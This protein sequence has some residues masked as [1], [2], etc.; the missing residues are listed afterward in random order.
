MPAISIAIDDTVH[1][2]QHRSTS[3][4][5]GP[6][7][8]QRQQEEE[9]LMPRDD[10]TIVQLSHKWTYNL[11]M[12]QFLR[13][14][15]KVEL[16]VHL[17]GSF[18]PSILLSHLKQTGQY[19]CLP[20]EAYCP[21]DQSTLA[22]RSSVLACK[23]EHEFRSL[24]TCRGKRSLGSMLQ[25]FTIFIPIVRGNL[26]LM[27]RLAYDFVKRQAKQNIIYTEVRYS[28]HLLAKGG[29]IGGGTDTI[30]D[31]IPVVDA[32][33]KGL[34]RGEKDFGIIVNQILC[35]IAWRPDW[36]DDVVQLAHDRRNDSPCAIV[37]VD[38]AAGE[39][40]FDK[41]GFPHLHE[42][43]FEAFQRAK[44]LGLNITIHAGEVGGSDFVCRAVNEYGATRIG[45]GYQIAQDPDVMEE[46]RR[47]NIHFEVCPTSSDETGGWMYDE[48]DGRDWKKHPAIQMMRYGLN[49]GLNSDDPAVFDTSLT[50]QYRIA[51]GKMGLTKKC[52]LRSLEYS[53]HS[54]FLDQEGKAMLRTRI[55]D[56]LEAE[57]G[58]TNQP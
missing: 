30:V 45:H 46:M 26:D 57:E 36:A 2:Q 8:G 37:G 55:K 20:T 21:W 53:I 42:P 41:D 1:F 22:V 40:H 12:E 23:T 9:V 6:A 25:C 13:R 44:E 48:R 33:T 7:G 39:E 10:A 32:V 5:R 3:T 54:A 17:D 52:I 27:E 15:P 47:K 38:I 31:P 4:S 56:Y 58:E 43:H 24:C 14:L 29:D 50:W 51:V 11:S 28:P 18:D 19:D 16:H 49:V 35:C 34:R